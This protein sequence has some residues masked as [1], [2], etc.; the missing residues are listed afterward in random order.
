MEKNDLYE[1]LQ[2]AYRPG[3]STE[4]ALLKI[5][6]DINLS[7]DQGD[8]VLLVLLD[9]SS[10]FDT[11]DHDILLE[12]LSTWCGVRGSALQ[13]LKSYLADRTQSVLIGEALS[14][15]SDLKTGVPQGSVLGPLVFT[16]YILPLGA[17]LRKHGIK[18]HVYADDTQLYIRF[19]PRDPDSLAQAIRR[20]EACLDDIIAWLIAN[21]L[22][23]NE[24]KTEFLAIVSAAFK[25]A[26]QQLKPTLRVG[27]ATITTTESTR[28]LGVMFDTEMSMRQ[29]ISNVT[30]SAYYHMRSISRARRYL[31][32]DTCAAMVRALVTSRLDYANC[33]LIGL[34]DK[35]VNRLQ[36]V[37][38]NAARLVTRTGYRSHI[39]PVLRELHWLRV[40][41]RVKHKVLCLTFKALH[42]TSAPSYLRELVQPYQP[43]RALRSSSRMQLTVP[44]TRKGN[45]DRAFAAYAPRLWNT[46]PLEVRSCVDYPAFQRLLKTF[47]FRECYF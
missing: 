37:Q 21:K 44:R 34:P 32:N 38:N 39:T 42:D 40:K 27:K 13:W 36:L 9:L 7:L 1:H 20:L 23:V 46:L 47:L 4:T 10:A 45:G 24:T 5:A 12:R 43:A 14:D 15:P 19:N 22:M 29:Q 6:S 35:L 2:S 41:Q 3:H 30:R 28:N 17:I 11:I 18:F 31:D 8:G 33:M 16:I 25:R 26:I